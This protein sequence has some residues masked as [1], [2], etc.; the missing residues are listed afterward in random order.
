MRHQ[1]ADGSW[2]LNFQEQC[3]ANGC[4]PQ[5]A[6]DSDTAA[7]GLALLPLLGAGYIHTEKC[8]HQDA[9]R[10]GIEW[11]GPAPAA[12]RRSVRG[13]TGHL[14][15][16]QPCDRQRWLCARP[17]DCLAIPGSRQPARRALDFIIE[18]QNTD[19]RRLALLTGPGRRYVGL[20]LAD[21]RPPERPPCRPVHPSDDAPR[22]FRLSQPGRRRPE[23]DPLLLPARPRR[24]AGHD[25]RGPGEPA[26]PGLAA[27]S[28]VADQGS[29]PSGRPPREGLRPAEHLLLVLRHPAPAQPQEQ[30]L[31]EV[32]SSTS[33]RS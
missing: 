33:A 8:R 28:P 31:G 15:H 9:V 14:L 18:A 6:L 25:G 23:E 16:V 10:R 21:L 1:R 17:M 19:E 22:L 5:R 32:E 26:A 20:R 24:L 3:Q 4:P 29:G 13:R 27:Q 7:T 2:S 30:G 11:P 12:Q